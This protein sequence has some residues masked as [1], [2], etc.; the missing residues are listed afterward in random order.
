M[1]TC[2]VLACVPAGGGAVR[3]VLHPVEAVSGGGQHEESLFA[4][5]VLQGLQ[6]ESA[7]AQPQPQTQPA[8]TAQATAHLM[9]KCWRVNFDIYLRCLSVPSQNDRFYMLIFTNQTHYMFYSICCC[10]KLDHESL[11]PTC[12]QQ[13]HVTDGWNTT[14]HGHT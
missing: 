3:D 2:H 7:G 14:K 12:V 10:C 11:L 5:A 8:G 4:V 1:P 13:T 9:L 6:G